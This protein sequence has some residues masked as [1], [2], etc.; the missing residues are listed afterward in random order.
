MAKRSDGALLAKRRNTTWA[1]AVRLRSDNAHQLIPLFPNQGGVNRARDNI[2]K[3][4][5][6]LGPIELV[7]GLL[8]RIETRHQGQP[9]Q[10]TEPKELVG[11]AMLIDKMFLGPQDRIVVEQAI[12]DINRSA[13]GA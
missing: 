8:A 1:G 3:S 9:Q 7:E 12:E 10:V 13:Y 11:E 6:G 4:A 2:I 5:I